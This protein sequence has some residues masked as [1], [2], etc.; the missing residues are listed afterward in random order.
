MP[1]ELRRLGWLG[2][3]APALVALAFVGMALLMVLTGA[4]ERQVARLLTAGLELGLPLV[5]GI[6]AAHVVTEEPAVDLQL[7]LETGY[8]TTLARRL[9]LLVGWT[10][11]ASLLWAGSLRLFGLWAVPGP[12]LLGQLS[13][14]APLLWFVAV[15]VLVALLLRSRTASSAVLGGIWLFE[16]TLGRVVFLQND[17]LRPFFLFATTYTPDADYW[18]WNRLA[19]LCMALVLFGL[20]PFVF[21]RETLADGGEA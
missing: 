21:S 15:G 20:V 17:W 3:A 7:T 18:L 8:R 19:I 16:N 14:L 13:W 2:L 5:A 9:A 6:V 11:L 12:F 10:A 4:E 1:Y